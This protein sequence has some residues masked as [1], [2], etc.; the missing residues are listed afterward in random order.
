MNIT[1]N[2]VVIFENGDTHNPAI[3]F[4]H[5]FPYDHQMWNK[6]IEG[7]SGDFY[8]VS[9]D[10]RGLGVSEPGDGQFTLEMFV[11]DLMFVLDKLNL[12]K[13]ILCGLSMG[14]YIG[15]RAVEREEDKFGGL[16]LCD[17]KANSDTDDVKL[18]RA[19]NVKR[20]NEEGVQKFAADFIPTCFAPESI[21]RLRDEYIKILGRSMNSNASAVKGCL[22]A[23]A[24][25]T[26]TTAYLPKIKIPTMVLCG[27]KDK[28][29]TPDAMKEMS[30]K[31]NGAEFVI[32]PDSGHMT[33]IE[34]PEFVIEKIR[35]F[36]SAQISK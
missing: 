32:V 6:V 36:I 35:K 20:I 16:I 30:D 14:G 18:K 27:E 7:L 21:E 4:V 12:N 5:G 23:M 1:K 9:Y 24:G 19:M 10:I 29:S 22:I 34:N 25:R 28:L 33:P 13:P 8:C 11:D 15:L 3:V 31:I 2:P 17:T 26:D